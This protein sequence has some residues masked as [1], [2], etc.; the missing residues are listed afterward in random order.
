MHAVLCMIFCMCASCQ[1]AESGAK[2][3]SATAEDTARTMTDTTREKTVIGVKKTKYLV[4]WTG[5]PYSECTWE[6]AKDISDD[7]VGDCATL[8]LKIYHMCD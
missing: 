5:L 2:C 1:L 4:K 7:Q 6:L 3:L 8:S